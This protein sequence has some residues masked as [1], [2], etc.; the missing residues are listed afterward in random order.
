MRSISRPCSSP[1]TPHHHASRSATT[2]FAV[3]ASRSKK[4]PRLQ[5]QRKGTP[6]GTDVHRLIGNRSRFQSNDI[7]IMSLRQQPLRHT[8]SAFASAL[9][10]FEL[11]W[12]G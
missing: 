12:I 5:I 11:D 6:W 4:V 10:C 1:E 9:G 7:Q 8:T 3:L 2:L